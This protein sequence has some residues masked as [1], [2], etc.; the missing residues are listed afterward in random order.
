MKKDLADQ[1]LIFKNPIGDWEPS[2]QYLSGDVR[3]KLRTAEAAATAKPAF[4][5]NVE[6]L[7]EVQPVDL[8]PSQIG[9]RMGAPWIP[10][11]DINNF[12][13]QLLD[14][15]T[16][17]SGGSFYKYVPET[18]DWVKEDRVLGNE[19]KMHSEWGTE[20]MGA[21]EIIFRLLNGKLVEVNDK[22]ADDKPVRNPTETVAAQEK[23][24]AIQA[25][26]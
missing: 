17:R 26:F 13:S 2:D 22:G 20:R 14:V 10:S 7:K 25:V 12:V 8:T 16:W 3:E 1:R 24:T 15:Y 6:A 23:A 9:V 19:A 5:I 4:N 21:N 18:G 11:E